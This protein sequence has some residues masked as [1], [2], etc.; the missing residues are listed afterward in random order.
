MLWSRIRVARGWRSSLAYYYRQ[1]IILCLPYII[2]LHYLQA[3]IMIIIIGMINRSSDSFNKMTDSHLAYKSVDRQSDARQWL[4]KHLRAP[5]A[6]YIILLRLNVWKVLI[7]IYIYIA[8]SK[9]I[10][11]RRTCLEVWC[12]LVFVVSSKVL[13][14]CFDFIF[15]L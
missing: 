6:I 5:D 12:K 14:M 8:L 9:I 10:Q 4:V 13:H 3:R 7:Y 2:Y 1:Y 11:Y 15:K